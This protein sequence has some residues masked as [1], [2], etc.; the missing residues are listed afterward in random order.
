MNE[1]ITEPL[2]P[3][4]D[5]MLE[6]ACQMDYRSIHCMEA[7]KPEC[8][9]KL[10]TTSVVMEMSR[11]LKPCCGDHEVRKKRERKKVYVFDDFCEYKF[12]DASCQHNVE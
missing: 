7:P 5:K 2:T 9:Q 3:E 10:D 8:F 1:I 11:T 12:V 6:E 4:E